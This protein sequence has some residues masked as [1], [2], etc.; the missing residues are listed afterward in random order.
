MTNKKLLIFTK[1]SMKG[2]SSRLRTLQY[3]SFLEQAGF[4]ITISSL[5]N[6]EYIERLYTNKKVNLISVFIRYMRRL[7]MVL[8][9]YKYDVVLIE[10]E[11]FPYLPSFF[12]QLIRIYKVPYVLDYDDAIFHNYDLNRNKLIKFLLG[13][14]LTGLLKGASSVIA[15][16]SYLAN[17]ASRFNKKDNIYI[18]PTVIDIARY[19]S[20]PIEFNGVLRIGWIGSPSTEKY[21]RLLWPVFAELAKKIPIVL[22]TIGASEIVDCPVSVESHEWSIDN[23]CEIL[24]SIHIGVMPLPDA[25]WENGKCG[26]KLIQYMASGRPVIASAVG[27]NTDIVNDDVGFIA[28]ESSDWVESIMYFSKNTNMIKVMGDKARTLVEEK[29]NT[30]LIAPKIESIL[31]DTL[32]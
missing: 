30:L 21:L 9:A 32:K 10:K 19:T 23:E 15:G 31:S 6:D 3:V 27:V 8:R 16:N 11:L 7:Y 4:S 1:Y 20:K 18:C 25:P 26:Y 14:K 13:N 28:R 5:F 29:Y 2:A 22:V 17:Y 12:E 24:S